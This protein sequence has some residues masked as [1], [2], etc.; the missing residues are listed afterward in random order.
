MARLAL[1]RRLALAGL[2]L[3]AFAAP[4]APAES[5]CD[6]QLEQAG[7]HLQAGRFDAVAEDVQRC[8]DARPSRREKARALSL[9]AKAQL[10]NDDLAAARR[11]VAE[12]LRNDPELE[13]D[14]F[15]MPRFARL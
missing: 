8:L 2:L 7:T 6:A 10:A 13:P 3:G 15:D 1:L 14:P 5:A 9:L 11:T 4:A 12:L